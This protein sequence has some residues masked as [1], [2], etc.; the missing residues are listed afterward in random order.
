LKEGAALA[1]R[2]IDTGAA[3]AV[4]ERLKQVS[5]GAGVA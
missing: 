4:L 3:G 5:K 2:S 1:Q